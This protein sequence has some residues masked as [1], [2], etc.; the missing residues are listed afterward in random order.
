MEATQNMPSR[1]LQQLDEVKL[2]KSIAPTTV[3]SEPWEALEQARTLELRMKSVSTRQLELWKFFVIGIVTCIENGLRH[4]VEILIDHG[5]PFSSNAQALADRT[6]LKIEDILFMQ[7]RSLSVGSLIGHVVPVNS[8]NDIDNVLSTLLGCNKQGKPRKFLQELKEAKRPDDSFTDHPGLCG[9]LIQ[10]VE[11]VIPDV[12][13][14]FRLRHIFVHELH[15]EGLVDP[16]LIKRLFSNGIHFLEGM[17]SFVEITI[18]PGFSTYTQAGMNHG[19]YQRYSEALSEME[20]SLTSL[21][22]RLSTSEKRKLTAAQKAWKEY[23]RKEMEF[24]PNPYK[25]GSAAP[26]FDTPARTRL[27]RQRKEILQRHHE[28][29]DWTDT[30]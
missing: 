14:L 20:A 24:S 13:E 8:L 17:L 18:D 27:I 22:K 21:R 9:S 26:L 30:L 1:L 23:V 19:V 4:S 12:K 6:T 3:S 25:G 5:T 28:V 29:K 7:G 11:K 10:D 2:R 16:K 15:N